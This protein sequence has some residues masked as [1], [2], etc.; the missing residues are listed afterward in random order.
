MRIIT[1]PS[2]PSISAPLSFSQTETL[3]SWNRDHSFSHRL[4]TTVLLSVP[5]DLPRPPL[6]TINCFTSWRSRHPMCGSGVGCPHKAMYQELASDPADWVQSQRTAPATPFRDVVQDAGE[7]FQYSNFCCTFFFFFSGPWHLEI[8]GL[9]VK[10]E[11]QLPAYTTA[12]ATQ[13][14]SHVCD[15][16]G[17]LQQPWILNPLSEAKDQIRILMD[18]SRILNPLSHQGN[19][20][21]PF[22]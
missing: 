20:T 9:G 21:P 22:F 8:P 1:Q 12:T 6:F 13:D 4:V 17:S 14:L 10:S 7:K 2:P 3:L 18:T 15:V 16:H 5:V 19:S 11:L